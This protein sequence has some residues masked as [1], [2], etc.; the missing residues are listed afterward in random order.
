MYF[1]IHTLVGQ[2]KAFTVSEVDNIETFARNTQPWTDIC[3][4]EA[5]PCIDSRELMK[6][7]IK[8]ISWDVPTR[9]IPSILFL[10][11][12]I[13]WE[14]MNLWI[15]KRLERTRQRDQSKQ[16]SADEVRIWGPLRAPD[17]GVGDWGMAISHD[18]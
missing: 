14:C 10:I 2:N 13:A 17:A 15:E 11:L 7:D 4:F 9:D 16:V 3:K 5:S 12:M 18:V 8:T 6:L 1:P